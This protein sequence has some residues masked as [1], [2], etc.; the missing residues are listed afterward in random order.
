MD[1]GPLVD[2]DAVRVV[3]V[4]G[5]GRVLL[6]ETRDPFDPERGWYWVTPGGGREHGESDQECAVREVLEETGLQLDPRDLGPVRRED[7]TQL[8]FEGALIRQ[9]Q[10]YFVVRV[11]PFVID[12]SG[13]EAAEMR[14][15]REVRWW[16]PDELATTEERF[17]PEELLALV[18]RAG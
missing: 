6:I 8:G 9:H 17:Y 5:D 7:T 16:T 18:T 13:W 3:L 12:T 2:R 14:S 11:D 15:Q 10:V 4:D 1:D